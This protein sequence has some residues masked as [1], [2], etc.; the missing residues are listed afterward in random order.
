MQSGWRWTVWIW[1]EWETACWNREPDWA[2]LHSNAPSLSSWGE[3]PK[4][5]GAALIG[6]VAPPTLSGGVRRWNR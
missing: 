2:H 5:T 3:P 1:K 6:L 4:E